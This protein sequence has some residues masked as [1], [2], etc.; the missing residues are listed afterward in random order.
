[1]EALSTLNIEPRGGRTRVLVIVGTRPE[2]I[3]LAPVIRALKSRLDLD[4]VTCSTGQHREMLDQVLAR[5]DI[6]PDVDLDLMTANQ[7][8]ARVAGD[9]FRHMPFHPYIELICISAYLNIAFGTILPNLYRAREQAGRYL[10]LSAATMLVTVAL[11]LYFVVYERWGAIGALGAAVGGTGVSDGIASTVGV[12]VGLGMGVW[13]GTGVGAI[14]VRV[15]V[16]GDVLTIVI[17]WGA[18]TSGFAW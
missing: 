8:P 9:L 1:M 4:V 12:R 11:T 10:A 17:P 16:S 15:T 14:R 6:V 5:F 18:V 13:V 3:K 2:A 7:T